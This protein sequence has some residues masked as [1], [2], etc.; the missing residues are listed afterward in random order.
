MRRSF[1][2]AVPV[3]IVGTFAL[4]LGFGYSINA[5]SLFGMVLAIGIVVDDAIVV[6]ENV[7]RNIAAGL[8]PKEATYQAMREVS[9]PIIAIALTLVAVFVP[10]AFM[11][12]LTGQFYKQFAMTIAIST[13][14]SAFNSLTLSPAMAALLLKDHHAEPDW[15]TR[16]MNR[17]LG[18]FFRA[19][20]RVFHRGSEKYGQGVTRVIGR[21]ALMMAIFAVLI[22]ATICWAKWY[23]VASCPP[24]TRSTSWRSRSCPTAHRSIARRR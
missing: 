20:N 4:L 8:S 24:R 16:Q 12:G 6:V 5:L 23:R 22:G 18:G 10:L 15:L 9:G 3:S 13:V 1:R 21:K 17:Y 7:E 2:L 11:S 19:F 14:I